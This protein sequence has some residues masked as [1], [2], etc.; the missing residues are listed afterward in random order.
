M[1]G[2]QSPATGVWWIWAGLAANIPSV[3]RDDQATAPI[4]TTAATPAMANRHASS[5]TST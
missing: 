5:S 4:R 3:L 1:P 2:A